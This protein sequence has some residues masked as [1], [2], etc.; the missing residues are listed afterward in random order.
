MIEV[1]HFVSAKIPADSAVA[2]QIKRIADVMESSELKKILLL[3]QSQNDP[4]WNNKN[5]WGAP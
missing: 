1:H 3:W 5:R 2:P 4:Y